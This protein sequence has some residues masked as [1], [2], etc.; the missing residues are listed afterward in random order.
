M[1]DL[2]GKTVKDLTIDLSGL[3]DGET[4]TVTN[5]TVTNLGVKNKTGVILDLNNLDITNSTDIN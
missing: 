2:K 1:F 5:G 3:V 4:I